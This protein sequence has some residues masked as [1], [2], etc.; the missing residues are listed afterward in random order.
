MQ[1]I[2][3]LTHSYQSM[4]RKISTGDNVHNFVLSLSDNFVLVLCDKIFE[5]FSIK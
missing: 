4:Y 5:W 3:P 1:L 2:F